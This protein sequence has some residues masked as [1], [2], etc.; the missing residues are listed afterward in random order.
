MRRVYISTKIIKLAEEYQN[1]L[2]KKRNANFD[3]PINDDFTSGKLFDLVNYL[4]NECS[5][6]LFADY[7]QIIIDKYSD[8]LILQPDNFQNFSDTNFNLTP[9]RLATIITPPTGNTTFTKKHLYEL[10]SDA[11]RY[12]AVREK[13]FLPYIKKMGLKSCVYCNAQHSVTTVD[14]N[15]GH[16]GKYELD[17]YFPK[18]KYP[19]LSISFFNLVLCCSNC[20]KS[21]LNKTAMFNLYTNDNNLLE[22]FKFSID[23]KS[24]LRYLLKQDENE[25]IIKFH[26]YNL[27]LKEN[28]ENT[29]HISEIYNQHKD[30]VEELIWKSIIYNKS[31]RA[32]L[33]NSFS[34]F[35]PQ[36]L[37]VNRFI[38]GN[39]GNPEEIHKRPLSKLVQDIARQLQII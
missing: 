19:F 5:E 1:N 24:I 12:D 29:F 10:I 26:S 20:N 27:A 37:D 11:M 34:K 15:G 32:S 13:E 35:F 16:S 6:P 14:D 30:I 18:S 36:T 9:A 33:S 39:Y 7:V 17:H 23:N 22:P 2:F 8:I 21:K 25:L 38:L 31:Y 4:K 28:H 3:K